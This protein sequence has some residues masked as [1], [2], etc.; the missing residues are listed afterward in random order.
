MVAASARRRGAGTALM[1]RAI[2]I[3]REAGC[4]KVNLIS[5]N[6]R[7]GAHD[8]YRSLGFEAIGQGFKAYLFERRQA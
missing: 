7:T 1:R 2:E 5:G 6:E 3:A 8:F 4:Y